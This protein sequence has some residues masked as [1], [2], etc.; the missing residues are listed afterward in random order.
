MSMPEFP[1]S[2]TIL[3]R[4]E[5]INSILTSIAMEETAL[6]HIINAEGE[7]IQY[8]LQHVN[9]NTCCAAMQMILEVNESVASLLEQIT[10]MQ[11]LLKNKMRLLACFLPLEEDT[12][13]SASKPERPKKPCPPP[14][15]CKECKCHK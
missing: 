12:N 6:S 10:D 15:H 8:V 14:N 4:E 5:S 11:L 3:S 9:T 2:D 1:E 7:K 13:C